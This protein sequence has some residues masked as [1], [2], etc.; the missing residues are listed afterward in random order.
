MQKV[1]G[2][3][4]EDRP[5]DKGLI[6]RHSRKATAGNSPGRQSGVG[7]GNKNKVAKR[8]QEAPTFLRRSFRD[9]VSV[10]FDGAWLVLR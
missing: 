7:S 1:D 5:M 6:E 8:R 3:K 2:T 10:D 9:C 4:I